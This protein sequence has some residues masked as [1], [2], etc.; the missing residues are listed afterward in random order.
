[1][2]VV[3]VTVRVENMPACVGTRP[4]VTRTTAKE[5]QNTGQW[6]TTL[7]KYSCQANRSKDGG[8]YAGVFHSPISEC[9]KGNKRDEIE[10]VM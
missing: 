9:F 4:H 3:R 8:K 2:L 1:M 6:L 5:A 7:A 10:G